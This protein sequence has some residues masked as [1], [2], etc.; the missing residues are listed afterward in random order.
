MGGTVIEKDGIL[1][2]KLAK[3]YW[4][5]YVPMGDDIVVRVEIYDENE[6]PDTDFHFSL[7]RSV[8]L[9]PAKL[10]L[11]DTDT[12]R[13]YQIDR[14]TLEIVRDGSVFTVTGHPTDDCY[15]VLS[16]G[17]D[18]LTA[19]VFRRDEQYQLIMN[20]VTGEVTAVHAPTTAEAL[21]AAGMHLQNYGTVFATIADKDKQEALPLIRRFY[22]LGFNIEATSGTANFLKKNGIRTHVMR[23][24]DEDSDE[25]ARALSQGHIAYVI[26]TRDIDSVGSASDGALIRRY[27]TENNVTI[28][29]SLD[30]VSVLLDV[31]EETTLTISTIDS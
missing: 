9:V 23:K 24:L 30:T 7:A 8:E 12:L 31:L 17:K 25:I 14:E 27:A 1:C 20:T 10:R 2:V 18:Q 11:I 3:K 28:M 5:Y 26:N 4:T 22:N 13:V 29:T 15:E 16:Y 21:Q 6:T 19:T